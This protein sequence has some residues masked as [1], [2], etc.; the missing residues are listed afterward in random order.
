MSKVKKKKSILPE[1]KITTIA[2][3]AILPILLIVY[4]YVGSENNL[5]NQS[6][7]PTP[8]KMWVQFSKMISDGSLFGHIAVSFRRVITG[9][10]IG[11]LAGVLLGMLIGLYTRLNQMFIALIGILRPIPPIAC[12]PLFILI[13]G[14]GE[15]SKTA[16]I[17]IGSFWP[18]LLNTIS[19]IHTTNKKLI[20]VA[21]V[22]GKNKLSILLNIILPSAVPSIF[23]GLRLGISTA[24]SCVVAA[25][26]IAST[27]GVGY[28]IMYARQMTKPAML[29][30]GIISIG[31][32]G[33][34]ID[35]FMQFLQKKIVYWENRR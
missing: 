1:N 5:F 30:V 10:L 13:L 16:L 21:E 22:F 2:L 9:Y 33:L 35:L 26:M 23:T 6:I 11:A 34:I 18:C 17:F 25:E 20:E 29:F 27:E 3:A 32:I 31:V 4:W 28:L 12:I 7:I 8:H 14:I 24:W 19:G 15:A